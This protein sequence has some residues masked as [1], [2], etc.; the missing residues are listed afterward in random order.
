V[1][2]QT[3]RLRVNGVGTTVEVSPN[4]T[5]LD[6]LRG[7][8][9]LMEVKVGCLSGEC[10]A[11]TVLLNGIAV[12]SCLVLGVQADDADVITVRGL[13]KDGHLHPLQQAFIEDGAVECGFCTPGFI[14]ASLA[15][16]KENPKPSRE[17][18]KAAMGGNICRCTG[19]ENIIKAIFEASKGKYGD[20]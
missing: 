13:S 7:R 10:G 20:L 3:I 1:K 12:N 15:Y 6:I 9:R 18:V 4:E 19:Y 5:L 14:L 17:E 16:L 11:C 2:S 8:L